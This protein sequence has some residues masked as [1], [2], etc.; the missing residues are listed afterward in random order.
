MEAPLAEVP[1]LGEADLE[2]VEPEVERLRVEVAAR[3]EAL[4]LVA[5]RSEIE[6]AVGDRAQLA[7]DLLPESL[8]EVGG[9]PVDLRAGRERRPDPGA[10]RTNPRRP[11]A[12]PRASVHLL[13]PR[14]ALE[15]SDAARVGPQRAAG[16]RR[17]QRSGERRVI[18]QRAQRGPSQAASAGAIGAPLTSAMPSFNPGS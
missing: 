11:R 13:L 2:R 3:V 5:V 18:E 10:G 7:R 6:R 9:G 8:D 12:S 15:P 1:D 16:E 14:I 17:G 4:R